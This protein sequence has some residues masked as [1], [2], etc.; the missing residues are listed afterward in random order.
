M[1]YVLL[2][3]IIACAAI[4]AIPALRLPLIS[5]PLMRR[6][7]AFLPRMGDTERI[8]LEAGT[9][10]WDGELFSGK[11][12]WRKLLDFTPQALSEREGSFLAGPVEELCAMIDDW[13]VSQTRDLPPQVWDFIRRQGF[14]GLVIPQAYGGL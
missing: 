7:R 8:A 11:P 1:A 9:V 12:D 13:Q 14:F 6:A 4:F 5:A 3:I 2:A 10:W